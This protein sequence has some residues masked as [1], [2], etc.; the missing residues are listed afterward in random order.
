MSHTRG[1]VDRHKTR[2]SDY[3]RILQDADAL[4]N[5]YARFRQAVEAEKEFAD[6]LRE[7]SRLTDQRNK[8]ERQLDAERVS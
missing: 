8:F 5:R 1:D 7:H 6:G 4:E 3:D 2:L